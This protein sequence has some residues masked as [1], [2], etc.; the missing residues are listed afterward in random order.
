[1]GGFFF[2]RGAG[3]LESKDAS[4]ESAN[5]KQSYELGKI[6]NLLEDNENRKKNNT[7]MMNIFKNYEKPMER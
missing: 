2:W 1:M 5:L 7:K 3:G 4:H 6:L